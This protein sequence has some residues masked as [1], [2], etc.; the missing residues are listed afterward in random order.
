MTCNTNLAVSG[1]KTYQSIK[2]ARR[3]KLT[4]QTIFWE[5]VPSY[6]PLT[7]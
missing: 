5:G 1:Q 6:L 2:I 3:P 4:Y 7:V